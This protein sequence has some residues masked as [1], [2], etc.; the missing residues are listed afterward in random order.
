[1]TPSDYDTLIRFNEHMSTY[2]CNQ[3]TRKSDVLKFNPPGVIYQS[4]QGVKPVVIVLSYPKDLDEKKGKIYQT[5]DSERFRSW[6]GQVNLS[7]FYMTNAVK[8]PKAGNQEPSQNEIIKCS[9]LYLSKELNL[10]KPH[11]IVAMGERALKALYP[12]RPTKMIQGM[13]MK[14]HKLQQAK[15]YAIYHPAFIERGGYKHEENCIKL[16]DQAFTENQICHQ[17]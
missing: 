9:K 1:M 17:K 16:L 5:P 6:F 8:C 14:T 12:D 10:I 7:P 11:V 15:V 4:K 2:Q 13:M 3:C